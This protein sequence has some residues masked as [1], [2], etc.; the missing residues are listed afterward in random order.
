MQGGLQGLQGPLPWGVVPGGGK[1][2]LPNRGT[3]MGNLTAA[4]P[5][6]EG[7]GQSDTV[8]FVLF[9]FPIVLP[10]LS[11]LNSLSGF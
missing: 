6:T 8:R 11:I 2:E 5:C 3:V 4:I 7:Q 1:A 9:L 10:L